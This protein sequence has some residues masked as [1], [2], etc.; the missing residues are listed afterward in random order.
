METTP[1]YLSITQGGVSTKGDASIGISGCAS[2]SISE[3]TS[4]TVTNTSSSTVSIAG[5]STREVASGVPSFS[6]I[7]KFFQRLRKNYQGVKM[8]KL[9]SLQEFEH[10]TSESL[11]EAYTRMRRLIS[12]THGVIEAQAI[13]YC[14][15]QVEA[16]VAVTRGG[17]RAPEPRGATVEYFG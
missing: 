8:E 2:S 5:G 13:Q 6:S 1:N 10:K 11:R 15:A 14:A 3:G 7:P 4:G 12:V 16:S 9:R 17:A